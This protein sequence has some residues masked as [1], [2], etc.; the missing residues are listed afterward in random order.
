[1][2][3]SRTQ[4]RPPLP[5]RAKV[6]VQSV[7][8]AFG[9][10]PEQLLGRSRVAQFVF[11]RQVAMVLTLE[12]TEAAV[13][14]VGRW[15]GRDHTTVSYARRVVERAESQNV[16][17]AEILSSLRQE[18]SL[19]TFDGR[20]HQLIKEIG[21]RAQQGLIERLEALAT[22]DPQDLVRELIPQLWSPR[23]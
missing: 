15:Y 11:P 21:G 17:I 4:I 3:N 7:A 18:L 6:V 14:Q 13:S 19:V 10:S 9:I 5:T 20:V 12:L 8:K 16:E 2:S 1:M 23:K 22:K